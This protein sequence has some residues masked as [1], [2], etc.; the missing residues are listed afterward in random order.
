MLDLYLYYGY[1]PAPYSIFDKLQKLPPAHFCII[2]DPTAPLVFQR[3]WEYRFDVD[4]TLNVQA[5]REQLASELS[6]A[7]KCHLVS[8]VPVGAFL[9]GG[10]DSSTV[11]AYMADHAATTVQA[12]TIGFEE[13]AFDE[14]QI[15]RESAKLLPIDYHEEQLKI[16]IF[17]TLDLLV[18]RYGEPFADSSALCT[19]RVTEL[20]ARSVKV[21]LSGDGGDEIFAGYSHYAW[22]LRQFLPNFSI[23]RQMRLGATD[24]LRFLGLLSPR[25]T[26]LDGWKGRNSYFSCEAR[27]SLWQSPYREVLEH[28]EAYLDDHFAVLK[29]A[30]KSNFLDIIQSLDIIDYL[31][32]NNLHKVDIASMCHGLEV[33]VPL[34]DHILAE[35]AAKIPARER[36]QPCTEDRAETAA[37]HG[38]VTKYSL[39]VIAESKFRRGFF[40]RKKMGFAVPVGDWLADDRFFPKLSEILLSSSSRLLNYFNRDAILALLQNHRATHQQGP[41]LWS[42]LFLS[43]WLEHNKL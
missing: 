35:F 30:R 9:S 14:R 38:Y 15:T 27:G 25:F 8:D 40:D 13:S 6:E 34:L 36:L 42:L 5:Y 16:D 2:K 7:V 32:N 11:V 41:K 23:M 37:M 33:R 19:Y 43:K 1:I 31:P 24:V 4:V 10:I 28:T 3:Y 29:K 12:Y 17:D 18:A 20:A 22:M 26:P 39:R 21:M